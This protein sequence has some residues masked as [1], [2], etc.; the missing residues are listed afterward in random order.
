MSRGFHRE[1]QTCVAIL[2]LV[3]EKNTHCEEI[4][5]VKTSLLW[6]GRRKEKNRNT[7]EDETLL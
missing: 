5:K 3:L 2:G 4:Q 6:R 7:K 1:V